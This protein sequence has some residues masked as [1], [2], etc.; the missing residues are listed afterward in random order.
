MKKSTINQTFIKVFTLIA[1]SFAAL[2]FTTRFGLDGYE[3]YLNNKL[4]LKQ[5]V[6]QPVNLR[7]LQLDKAKDND[8]LR[9]KY[10]H[11][12]NKGAGT[13]RSIALKDE[14][15]NTLKKWAFADAAGSD[16]SMV[17]PVKELL[18]LEKKNA[19]HELSLYYTA[20]ELPKSEMLGFVR[21]K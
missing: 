19:G 7:V 20:R 4:L 8:E 6:N 21:V 1:F 3:V 14:Q 18:Q 15:G 13:G 5:Y 16:L 17:V 2:G 9:I 11:C 10:T 12:S